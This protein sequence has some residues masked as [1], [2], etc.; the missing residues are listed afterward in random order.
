MDLEHLRK[1]QLDECKSLSHVLKRGQSDAETKSA[2]TLGSSSSSQSATTHDQ[3]NKETSQRKKKAKENKSSGS[4]S[5]SQSCLSAVVSGAALNGDSEAEVFPA[6]PIPRSQDQGGFACITYNVLLPNSQ[7]GWWLYKYYRHQGEFTEWPVRQA[8][9]RTQLIEADVDVICLQ[10]LCEISFY[11]DFRFLV[12]AGYE[13]LLHTKAARMRP[14]TFWRTSEWELVQAQHKDRILVTTLRKKTGPDAGAVV[15]FVNGHLSAGHNADRR[16][17]QVHEALDAITKEAKRLQCDLASLPVVFCG[18]FN[19][20]GQSGVRELLIRGEIGPDFRETGDPTEKG[21]DGKQL[22]SK[23]RR[24]GLAL[25]AD[26]AEVAYKNAPPATILVS[27]ID[28]KMLNEDGTLTE[29]MTDALKAAFALCLPPGKDVMQREDVDR[30]LVTVNRQLGR[31]S[32]YRA[33]RAAFERRGEEVLDESDFIGI[34][35]DELEEGKFWGVEHDLVAIGGVEAGLALPTEGP[36]QLRFDYIFYTRGP[37]KLVGVCNPL[38]DEH[39]S[40]IWGEPWEILPN[41]WHPS[42]HLPVAAR[43]SLS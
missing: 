16:L 15:V 39:K 26:A 12:D 3:T 37:L 33:A 42:D 22:T 35:R 9:L 40:R 18:D 31:G 19:S 6:G 2:P 11:D 17:R 38:T 27:N 4:A 1:L 14:G 28:S 30:W 25:F 36:C 13:A 29:R 20:Q 24:H 23:T 10:E 8:L 32:E 43:F 34:Y 5:L 21:Q 41:S 7:D